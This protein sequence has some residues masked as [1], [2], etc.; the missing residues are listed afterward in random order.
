MGRVIVHWAVRISTTRVLLS[1]PKKTFPIRPNFHSF[2]GRISF[3]MTTKSS[4]SA[5]WW[6]YFHLYHLWNSLRYFSFGLLQKFCWSIFQFFHLLTM[7][8]LTSCKLGSAGV[9][10][11]VLIRKCPWVNGTKFDESSFIA[12]FWREF[13]QLSMRGNRVESSSNVNV[14]LRSFSNGLLNFL[15]LLP[16]IHPNVKLLVG[17]SAMKY[18]YDYVV[19]QLALEVFSAILDDLWSVA[20]RL[21]QSSFRCRNKYWR[22]IHA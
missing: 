4:T 3:L 13:K 7:L 16:I 15:R 17:W 9:N 10:N 19:L 1:K 11:R 5:L 6:G 8:K 2:G 20:A 22:N 12:L 14:L 18:L 21:L